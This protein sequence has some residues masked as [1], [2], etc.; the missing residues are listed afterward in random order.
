MLKNI[1]GACRFLDAP[2]WPKFAYTTNAKIDSKSS[3][4][5]FSTDHIPE[6]LSPSGR[7]YG[8]RISPEQKAKF[9]IE[10]TVLL[11]E[12]STFSIQIEKIRLIKKYHLVDDPK[13]LEMSLALYFSLKSIP[14][15][16][17]LS[18]SGT[19]I[20]FHMCRSIILNLPRSLILPVFF[21]T[22]NILR[23]LASGDGTVSSPRQ[24]SALIL[25]QNATQIG[26]VCPFLLKE[27]IFQM[28]KLKK[29]DVELFAKFCQILSDTYL[30]TGSLLEFH[31]LSLLFHRVS[32]YY[33]PKTCLINGPSNW[34]QFASSSAACGISHDVRLDTSFFTIPTLLDAIGLIQQIFPLPDVIDGE[35]NND[36]IRI[37]G[38]TAPKIIILYNSALKQLVKLN[39]FAQGRV[40]FEFLTESKRQQ[41]HLGDATAKATSISSLPNVETFKLIF[42]LY[43]HEGVISGNIKEA[44]YVLYL[45]LESLSYPLDLCVHAI[46]LLFYTRSLEDI[47]ALYLRIK[48][49]SPEVSKHILFENTFLSCLSTYKG[50]SGSERQLVREMSEIVLSNSGKTQVIHSS[51]TSFLIGTLYRFNR[52]ALGDYINHLP[53]SFLSDCP[54][55]F[56]YLIKLMI[57]DASHRPL[58]LSL[59]NERFK[60]F[61]SYPEGSAYVDYRLGEISSLFSR[62]HPQISALLYYWEIFEHRKKGLLENV[63]TTGLSLV[64]KRT[65][66]DVERPVL[67]SNVHYYLIR[68]LYLEGDSAGILT[69]FLYFMKQAKD[70][71]HS[72]DWI[73][74]RAL[75]FVVWS[76]AKEHEWSHLCRLVSYF[77]NTNIDYCRIVSEQGME[78]QLYGSSADQNAM[79]N[80]RYAD[81]EDKKKFKLPPFV[82]T[83]YALMLPRLYQEFRVQIDQYLGNSSSIAMLYSIGGQFDTDIIISTDEKHLL[84]EFLNKYST[85]KDV[86]ND[87]LRNDTKLLHL[88]CN[89]RSYLRSILG[90]PA[91]FVDFYEQMEKHHKELFSYLQAN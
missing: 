43:M 80:E 22:I 23:T 77:S 60:I 35:K 3:A 52:R 72:Y 88:N 38:L 31:S 12:A 18:L 41:D 79:N 4:G 42:T 54:M 51:N 30:A 64:F 39:A 8:G 90:I 36:L 46:K 57:I 37:C 62:N 61:D 44:I 76:L 1:R 68:T 91:L 55:F 47:K 10:S 85:I 2:G 87:I 15:S 73:S 33:E 67:K 70:A 49:T 53:L 81:F 24:I 5:S 20:H 25:G 84:S 27:K 71:L 45:G 14:F 9:I 83:K 56:S 75:D 21:F 40:L 78:S 63:H 86:R 28:F 50:I 16:E 26:H 7:I 6:F 69:Y 66:T 17:Q 29:R 11:K 65:G 82:K 74:N 19:Y 59:I 48:T 89:I 32:L 13:T 34:L 58:L